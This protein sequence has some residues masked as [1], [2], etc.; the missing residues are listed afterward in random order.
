MPGVQLGGD[1]IDANKAVCITGNGVGS[2]IG[3][4][5]ISTPT[6]IT[7]DSSTILIGNELEKKT[8]VTT[9]AITNGGALSVYKWNS[10]K[11]A[12]EKEIRLQ[13]DGLALYGSSRST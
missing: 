10:A 12:Q 9:L 11:T 8:G 2:K 1:T 6:S 3:P 13:A 5:T 7:L 4:F